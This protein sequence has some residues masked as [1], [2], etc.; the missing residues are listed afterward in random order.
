MAQPQCKA[1]GL[2]GPKAGKPCCHL[3]AIKEL[4]FQM[5][6]KHVHQHK[7]ECIE[8]DKATN[9]KCNDIA[10]YNGKCNGHLA[11]ELNKQ[12]I[13]GAIMHGEPCINPAEYNGK[14]YLHEYKDKKKEEQVSVQVESLDEKEHKI[15][16]DKHIELLVAQEQTKQIMTYEAT[17]QV[18]AQ[19]KTKQSL[20]ISKYNE[21]SSKHH[22]EL[23]AI[24]EKTKQEEFRLLAAQEK[25]KQD[26]HKLMLAKEQTKQEEIKLMLAK[27]HTRQEEIKLLLAKE[28]TNQI[29]LSQRESCECDE[30]RVS[31]DRD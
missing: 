15:V 3:P 12:S 19:E 21:T 4:D 13:C 18:E 1:V 10:Q 7:F 6:A 31:Y 2:W 9:L 17:K 22:K 25:T 28:L 29:T 8:I 27:E 30:C 14:C 26:E 24:M 11:L 5:C 16:T 20:G 23:N